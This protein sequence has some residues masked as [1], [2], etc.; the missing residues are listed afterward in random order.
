MITFDQLRAASVERG[1]V[2][3]GSSE[4]PA[5]F[6]VVELCGEVGELANAF[7]KLERFRLGLVGG[8]SDP[9]NLIEEIGDVVICADLLA[10]HLGIDLGKAVRDKF[11]A[12]SRKHGFEVRL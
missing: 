1:K 7:K 6:R 10:Q 9:S 11:N 8:V 12:T 5:S 4:I 2:W 3:A